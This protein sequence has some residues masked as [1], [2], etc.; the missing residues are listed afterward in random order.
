MAAC[1]WEW[2]TGKTIYHIHES[3]NHQTWFSNMLSFT[4]RGTFA[5]CNV[6]AFTLPRVLFTPYFWLNEYS[7]IIREI[8]E[9]VNAQ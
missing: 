9:V 2:I 8:E 4:S 7:Q 5:A 1:V 3:L 6:D